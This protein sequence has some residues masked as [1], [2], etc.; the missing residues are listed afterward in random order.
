MTLTSIPFT[1]PTDPYEYFAKHDRNPAQR[2]SSFQPPSL[3][4]DLLQGSAAIRGAVLPKEQLLSRRGFEQ[5]SNYPR[6]YDNRSQR[7]SQSY[8]AGPMAPRGYQ[9]HSNLS[10]GYQQGSY[11]NSSHLIHN[12]YPAPNDPRGYPRRSDPRSAVKPFQEDF[13]RRPEDSYYGGDGAQQ[14][15]KVDMHGK[16]LEHIP[17]AQFAGESY[18]AQ[19]GISQAYQHSAPHRLPQYP[20]ELN[21]HSS[22]NFNRAIPADRMQKFSAR[23]DNT[24][25][26]EYDVQPGAMRAEFPNA[27]SQ[28]HVRSVHIF[29]FIFAHFYM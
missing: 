16:R 28:T 7:T 6:G 29:S 9:Q 2:L 17:P 10:Q 24:F 3:N 26:S 22:Q 25:A 11:P 27:Y 12:R 23:M 19:G 13:R 5:T 8:Q 18:Y 21:P 15:N 20:P 4:V 14:Q 1:V